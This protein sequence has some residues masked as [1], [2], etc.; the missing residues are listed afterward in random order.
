MQMTDGGPN[1]ASLTL[2]LMNYRYGF[3][4]NKPQLAMAQGVIM[5][6]VLIIFAALYFKVNKKIEEEAD[7]AVMNIQKHTKKVSFI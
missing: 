3:V 1:N 6:L 2:G 5:F 4:M 7:V